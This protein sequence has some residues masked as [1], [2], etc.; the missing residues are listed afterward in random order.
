[1]KTIYFDEAGYTGNNLLD[2]AQ[3]Y[4]CYLGVCSDTGIEKMFVDLK[5]KYGYA[6][7]E[8][9][10]I[11]LSKSN[12]GEKFIAELWN[13]LKD[14]VKYVVHD[15]KMALAAKLFEYTYEPVFADINTLLYR[16]G[17]HLFLANF[18][19]TGFVASDKNAED[20]FNGF[21]SFVKSKI[22][23]Y[24]LDLLGNKPEKEH[25]LRWFYDFCK[26]NMAEIASDVDFSTSVEHWL[27]D[28][29]NTSLYSLLI[30]FAG[31]DAEPLKVFCDES[32]PLQTELEGINHFVGDARIL[33]QNLIGKKMRIN[34]NLLEPVKLVQSS[35]HIS[36]Q[37]A[38]VLVSSIYYALLH[39]E[40]KFSQDIFK[41]SS[42]GF[43]YDNS[44]MPANIFAD[45]PM[46]IQE[47]H[48]WLMKE[49]SRKTN[50]DKK[51][52]A[53]ARH[54]FFIMQEKCLQD[55]YKEINDVDEV[56]RGTP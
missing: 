46:R 29:T 56:R 40:K 22:P 8:I 30:Q 54:D 26:N 55:M 28:L 39:Q 51:I 36:I 25:P 31:N 17:F 10:G 9:K 21:Y 7:T 44:V 3:P 37:I 47:M 11:T 19:Y 6:N 20:I 34:F 4:Y 53:I 50:K 14:N 38:D 41:I 45:Y 13:E 12:K 32:K 49:L 42:N 43:I 24:S 35:N 2:K 52:D 23:G 48:F 5:K 27:L 18:F 1:M 16:S 33:Y 15:K